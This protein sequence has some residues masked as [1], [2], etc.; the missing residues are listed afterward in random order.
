MH[1]CTSEVFRNFLVLFADKL[2]FISSHHCRIMPVIHRWIATCKIYLSWLTECE[3]PNACAL[4]RWF[5]LWT[6]FGKANVYLAIYFWMWNG[7]WSVRLICHGSLCL[8]S[9]TAFKFWALVEIPMEKKKFLQVVD[10]LLENNETHAHTSMLRS[11]YFAA[12]C[13]CVPAKSN[14]CA[15]CSW[16]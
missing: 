13:V 1:I 8:T 7:I 12:V 14:A 3:L 10:F 9:E 6:S 4:Y 11:T 16:F 15:W 2:I 5:S